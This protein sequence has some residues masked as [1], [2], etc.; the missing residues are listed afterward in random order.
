MSQ[1][2]RKC[3]SLKIYNSHE[4]TMKEISLSLS[5]C[6]ILFAMSTDFALHIDF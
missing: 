5:L 3:V 4:K 2:V 6:A 1:K